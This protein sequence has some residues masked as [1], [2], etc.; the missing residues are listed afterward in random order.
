VNHW[1]RWA[2]GAVAVLSLIYLPWLVRSANS[3]VL[4]LSVPFVVGNV[5]LLASVLIHWINNWTRVVPTPHLVRRGFEPPVAVIIPTYGEPVHMV[6]RTVVS[7]L[8][9]DYPMSQ[10]TVMVS[11]DGHSPDMESMLDELRRRYPRTRLIYNEPPL[12]GDPVRRGEAKA[13]N[14][15]AAM[16]RLVD[17]GV[18]AEFIETRD[19]DDLVGDNQFLRSCIGQLRAREKL[20]FVQTVK[21]GEVSPGDPFGNLNSTFYQAVMFARNAANAVFPC[22]SGLVWRREALDD[23]GWFNDWN[24]VEDLQSGVDALKKGWSSEYLGIVG[25][26]AQSSP[27]DLPN[28]YKQR[29]TWALDTARLMIWGSLKG[30]GLRQRLQFYDTYLHYLNSFTWL[31]LIVVTAFEL[32]TNHQVINAPGTQITLFFWPMIIA[33]ELMHLANGHYYAYDGMWRSRQLWANLSPLWAMQVLRALVAGPNRKPVYKVTRKVARYGWYWKLVLP[34]LVIFVMLASA[35]VKHLA[36]AESLADLDTGALY[37]SFFFMLL[38]GSFIPRS[39]FGAGPQM[40]FPRIAALVRTA[41]ERIGFTLRPAFAIA[42]AGIGA[43]HF[44]TTEGRHSTD[45]PLRS[46]ST[47]IGPAEPVHMSSATA[48]PTNA[49]GPGD[50]LPGQS[51]KV[52]ILGAG[53]GGLATAKFLVEAGH[54]VTVFEASSMYGGLAQSFSWHGINCDLAPHRFYTDDDALRD[55]FLE[56]VPMHQLVRRSRIRLRDQWIGD[57]V[58][59]IDIAAKFFPKT[60][61]KLFWSY[62]FRDRKIADENFEAMAL[63]R[64]GKTLNQLFFKPYSEKLFGVPADEISADWGRRKLRVSGFKDFIR[65]KSKLYFKTFHYPDEGGYGAICDALYDRVAHCVRLNSRVTAMEAIGNGSYEVTS[66]SQEGGVIVERYDAVVSTLP[67]TITA[68]LLGGEFDLKYRSAFLYYLLIDKPQVMPDHWVYFADGVDT[69]IINRMSEFKNFADYGDLPHS[70]LCAEVTATEH[71]SSE[72]VV[73][74]I[75]AAGLITADQVLDR[76][77]IRIPFAYPIYDL[78]SD[79]ELQRLRG[80]LEE[81]PY[82][83]LVGRSAKFA[84]QDVDEIYTDAKRVAA[85]LTARGRPARDE[86]AVALRAG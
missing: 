8:E 79:G 55:E 67:A 41:A 86:E 54:D 63:A 84:H 74:E 30:L 43:R 13:G 3:D 36:A 23:I 81:H 31:V 32:F 6:R 56:L 66:E 39:W 48:A 72:R 1:N 49:S 10:L 75:E 20:A 37:F 61:F 33:L 38:F 47:I 15:N 42:T 7:V 71:A 60:S 28:V 9:Q 26:F 44:V 53:M 78:E 14:L 18:D 21:T 50:N 4:W 68:R 46:S 52:A 29:G 12:K 65:R 62:L 51:V 5:L 45:S 19:A 59:P 73:A 22:G 40:E 82:L 17:E 27:E 76:K 11:D 83:H 70:V 34:Q 69:N 35:T 16:Q 25:A 77:L 24:L 85:A 57:P 64:Y 2:G 58:N 80:F